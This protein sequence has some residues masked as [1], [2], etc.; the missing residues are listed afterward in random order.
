M[1]H[2]VW[3]V[4]V[5][6]RELVR[7]EKQ[8]YSRAAK[9]RAVGSL[10]ARDHEYLAFFVCRN[11]VSR[12]LSVYNYMKILRSSHENSTHQQ[13]NSQPQEQTGFP[14]GARDDLGDVSKVCLWS[15]SS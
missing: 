15:Q 4:Q 14:E 12:L 10:R 1:H 5:Y 6:Q 3:C 2:S 7:L 13:D 8:S 11:P 9:E